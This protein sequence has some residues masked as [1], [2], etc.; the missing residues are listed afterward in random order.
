MNSR[1]GYDLER[2]QFLYYFKNDHL[3]T[4]INKA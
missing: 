2:E 4:G 1:K 3:K